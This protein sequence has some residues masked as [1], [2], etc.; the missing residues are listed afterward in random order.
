MTRRQPSDK[1]LKRDYKKALILARNHF[2]ILMQQV[3]EGK[4]KETEYS[5]SPTNVSNKIVSKVGGN[6]QKL[7]GWATVLSRS[8]LIPK[9]TQEQNMFLLESTKLEGSEN[10]DREWRKRA[11]ES[12]NTNLYV[13]ESF[14]KKTVDCSIAAND[15]LRSPPAQIA[16]NDLFG[17]ISPRALATSTATPA[18]QSSKKRVSDNGPRNNSNRR[19]NKTPSK[20]KHGRIRDHMKDGKPLRKLAPNSVLGIQTAFESLRITSPSSSP[21]NVEARKKGTRDQRSVD[22]MKRFTLYY[23]SYHMPPFLMKTCLMRRVNEGAKRRGGFVPGSPKGGIT[24]TFIIGRFLL[25]N[26][27]T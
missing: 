8:H 12:M 18:M 9:H 20:S 1:Q 14:G 16:V 5:A 19:G 23:Q 21:T 25:N 15:A 26:A 27:K 13:P 11:I 22:F 4:K 2:A 17:H 10:L 24:D 6:S 3:C 7:D